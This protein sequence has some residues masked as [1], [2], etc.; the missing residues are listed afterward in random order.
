MIFAMSG[1]ITA[2]LVLPPLLFTVTDGHDA[3]V[4]AVN[5]FCAATL[6]GIFGPAILR[7]PSDRRRC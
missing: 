1:T 2:V 5:A 6:M 7:D 4:A 3:I